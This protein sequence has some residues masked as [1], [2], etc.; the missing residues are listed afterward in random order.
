M[1][2]LKNNSLEEIRECIKEKNVI[3]ISGHQNPDGDAIGACLALAMSLQNLGKRVYVLLEDYGGKYDVIPGKESLADL[4][5]YDALQPELFISL[6]CGDLERLGEAAAVCRRSPVT[7]VIDHHQNNGYFGTLNFVDVKKSSAS[8]IVFDLINGYFP[9]NQEIAA[10]LYVG[11]IY[12]T[13]AFRH[14]S[15]SPATMAAAGTLMEM[16]IPFTKLYHLFFDSRSFTEL[17]LMGRAFDNAK[18]YFNGKLIITTITLAEFEELEGS[19]KELDAIVNYIKGVSGTKIAC[20]LYQKKEGVT[21]ASFRAEDGFNVCAL[22]MHFGGGGHIKAAG[23]T[24]CMSVPEA[25]Q[26]IIDEVKK[27]M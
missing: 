25:K 16:D 17:K 2:L 11:I 14:S 23:C 5:Q 12:D 22:A 3:A 9:I 8:E 15:T 1:G 18:L 6:D 13:G 4:R 20:F 7:I 26:M 19:L 27:L 24:L 10:A 21:K